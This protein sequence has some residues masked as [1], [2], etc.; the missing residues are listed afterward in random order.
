MSF[1]M[2][3]NPAVHVKVQLLATCE[4][5]P[6]E[7]TEPDVLQVGFQILDLADDAQLALEV[8][9]VTSTWFTPAEV[10]TLR[11]AYGILHKRAEASLNLRPYQL[12]LC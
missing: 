5:L 8:T 4:W 10:D 7:L 9:P 11:E 6:F 1:D 3:Q 12:P 2:P